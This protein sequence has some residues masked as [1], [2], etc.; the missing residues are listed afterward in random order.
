MVM[1]ILAPVLATLAACGFG[2]VEGKSEWTKSYTLAEGG[3]L[4]IH[5]TNG[6]IDIVPSDGSTVSVVAERIAHAAT[7]AAAKEAAAA[8]QIKES[9][10]PTRIA[11]DARTEGTFL[12][13]SREVK[14][15]VK[16]PVWA[17]VTIDTTNGEV[18][19]HN[20]TG[21][22]KVETTNGQIH[23]DGL[24]G[25]TSVETTNGEIVLEYASIP[26]HGITCSATNGEITVTIPK[27]GNA[28]IAADVTNGGISTENLTLHD[29]K[30]ERRSLKATLNGGGPSI[31]IETTNG[32]IKIRGR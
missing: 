3:T 9:V 1:S 30:E 10:S 31:K 20:I 6:E 11:L 29:T 15:H 17:A 18:S 16:A 21:D 7:E 24:A 8:I 14:F 12:D 2:G 23:G 27:D 32:G 26:A 4:E 25:S 19:I 28:H 13:G 5:S 22:L